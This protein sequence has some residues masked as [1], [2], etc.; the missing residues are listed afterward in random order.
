MAHQLIMYGG[1]G[2]TSVL[3]TNPLNAKHIAVFSNAVKTVRILIN[4]P[5]TQ[6]AIGEIVAWSCYMQLSLHH[7]RNRFHAVVLVILWFGNRV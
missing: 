5:A 7:N 4:T 6:G 1:A 3:Y 2:H